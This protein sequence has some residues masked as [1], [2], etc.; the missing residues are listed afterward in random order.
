MDAPAKALT[1]CCHA[2]FDLFRKVLVVFLGLFFVPD[3]RC[4]EEGLKILK[5]SVSI[6]YL[7]KTFFPH[8]ILF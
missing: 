8:L 7:I 5:I 2:T 4:L 3:G 1:C 6:K